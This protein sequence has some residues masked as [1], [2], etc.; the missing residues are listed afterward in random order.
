MWGLCEICPLGLVQEHVVCIK[1]CCWHVVYVNTRDVVWLVERY[2]DLHIVVLKSNE[3]KCHGQVPGEEQREI[4]VECPHGTSWV[5]WAEVQH[6]VICCSHFHIIERFVVNPKPCC[7][8]INGV[9]ILPPD[10][11]RDGLYEL[12]HRVKRLDARLHHGN[13]ENA[14]LYEVAISRNCYHGGRAIVDVKHGFYGLYCKIR[15]ANGYPFPQTPLGVSCQEYI[16][17]T[18]RNQLS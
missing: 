3:R 4:E 1:S 9:H 8:I 6:S 7:R 10:H 13:L 14:R 2:P 5:F 11:N 12:F 18:D 17:C 16:L 15:P